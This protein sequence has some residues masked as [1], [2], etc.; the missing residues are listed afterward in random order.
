[1]EE[2]DGS[3][4]WEFYFVWGLRGVGGGQIINAKHEIRT[5][6]QGQVIMWKAFNL[7]VYECV[8]VCTCIVG[9]TC[10]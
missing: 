4:F 3:C 10:S 8:S 1:M 5:F 9:E 6:V 2:V 7:C